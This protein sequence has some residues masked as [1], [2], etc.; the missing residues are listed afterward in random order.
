MSL[1][2]WV[3]DQKVKWLT[4]HG[5]SKPAPVRPSE[6]HVERDGSYALVDQVAVEQIREISPDVAWATACRTSPGVVRAAL[7]FRHEVRLGG[8]L[9]LEISDIICDLICDI[10]AVGAGT[11]AEIATPAGRI[12]VKTDH[13]DVACLVREVF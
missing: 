11:F 1:S 6:Q 13:I 5:R 2:W 12:A 10:F 7:E 9:L 8:R 4:N 3:G